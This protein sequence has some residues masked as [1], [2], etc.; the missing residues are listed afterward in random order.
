MLFRSALVACFSVCIVSTKSRMSGDVS[1]CDIQNII[2]VS[3][4][5]ILCS[6]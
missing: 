4:I 6:L 2:C 3:F 5:L 1:I